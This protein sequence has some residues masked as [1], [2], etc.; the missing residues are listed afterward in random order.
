MLGNLGHTPFN[1][2]Q[3]CRYITDLGLY[4]IHVVLQIKALPL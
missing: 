2:F 4:P 1:L 3:V